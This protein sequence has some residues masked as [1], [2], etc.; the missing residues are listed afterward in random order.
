MAESAEH[1]FVY[2]FL[3]SIKKVSV[4]P[5]GFR[6]GKTGKLVAPSSELYMYILLMNFFQYLG[7]K[8]LIFLYCEL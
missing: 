3:P 1:A 2:N 6:K 4:I 7:Q 5:L 8:S